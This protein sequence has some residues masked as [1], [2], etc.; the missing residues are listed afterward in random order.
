MA[1]V[2]QEIEVIV[3]GNIAE[4]ALREHSEGP[5]VVYL[6]AV[7]MKR[8]PG[9]NGIPIKDV[10][11]RIRDLGMFAS[12]AHVRSL[13]RR[14]QGVFWDVKSGRIWLHGIK[15]VGKRLDVR[16]A[17]RHRQVVGTG[18]LRTRADRRGALLGVALPDDK[19]IRQ[20]T[21]RVLTGVAP[22]TQR[23]YRRRGHFSARRQDADLT[24]AAQVPQAW[25]R[26][27]WA[28]DH[29]E[30]GVYVAAG[31]R[32]LMKRIANQYEPNGQRLPAGR[33]SRDVFAAQPLSFAKGALTV[34]RTFFKTEAEWVRCRTLKMG[35]EKAEPYALP[36]NV[37]YIERGDQL[38]E[39]VRC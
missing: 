11:D 31:G 39:A 17:N 25:M 21:V 28:A 4:A 8:S 38:W 37:A 3:Y 7:T 23:R 24:Q 1:S 27:Q 14:G 6:M 18:A 15:T 19:P 12:P 2:P 33:R 20:H 32:T 26:R 10:I 16:R 9:A 22:R 30:D 36:F 35:T 29:A 5:L 13:I 34:P